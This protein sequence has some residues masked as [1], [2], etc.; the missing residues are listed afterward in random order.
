[1]LLTDRNGLKKR[2]NDLDDL[3][4]EIEESTNHLKKA[5]ADLSAAVFQPVQNKLHKQLI[6][7]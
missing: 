5:A 3:K 4:N 7:P 2:K 6:N 1:M